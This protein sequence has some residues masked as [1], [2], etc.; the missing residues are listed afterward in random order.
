MSVAGN[1]NFDPTVIDNVTAVNGHACGMTMQA[2]NATFNDTSIRDVYGYN[3]AS[4][5]EMSVAGN[6]NFDPTVIDNVTAVNGDAHGIWMY[7]I[8]A[9]ISNGEIKNSGHGIWVEYSENTTITGIMIINNT[10]M[11]TGVHLTADT[12]NTEIHG[13]CFYDN[14]PQAW[15]NGTNNNWTGNYWSDWTPPGPYNISGTA[16]SK[17]NDPLDECPLKKP[18]VPAPVRVPGLTPIGMITLV[19]LLSVVLAMSISIR[20]K[21]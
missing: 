16:K 11:D 2:G 4:G 6:A 21:K 20:R 7:V 10:E 12:N 3:S 13:N 9:V 15:D 19:G 8:N 14:E 5:I 18:P 1:A 17:D